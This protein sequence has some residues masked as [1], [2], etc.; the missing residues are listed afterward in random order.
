MPME[1]GQSPMPESQLDEGASERL[2]ETIG[3]LRHAIHK[4]N[5]VE[6]RLL[7]ILAKSGQISLKTM[8]DLWLERLQLQ[9][10]VDSQTTL[11]V[12]A[13]RTSDDR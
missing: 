2:G 1:F 12:E 11:L 5:D 3:R 4:R 10:V 8:T 7:E 9:D 6:Q 13:H